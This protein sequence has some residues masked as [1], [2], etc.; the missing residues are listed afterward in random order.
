MGPLE[1]AQLLTDE[2]SAKILLATFKN[3]QSAMDLSH[4][5]GIPLAACYRR[6]SQLEDFG[7]IECVER[8]LTD[9]GKRINLYESRLKHAYVFFENGKLRTRF[10]ISGGI[11]KEIGGDWTTDSIRVDDPAS[12]AMATYHEDFS[13]WV[14][15][16]IQESDREFLSKEPNQTKEGMQ[17][18][19]EELDIVEETLR[20]LEHVASVSKKAVRDLREIAAR[21]PRTNRS[22]EEAPEGL[23]R[24]P[25]IP[26]EVAAK[27]GKHSKH[28]ERG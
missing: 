5:Y 12:S 20:I 25:G 23:E 2:Y 24:V 22:L 4:K 11:T 13:P 1:A 3:R 28:G 6:L 8:T 15:E 16:S 26:K 7:L 21:A 19:I 10:T 9:K 14:D 18:D 27:T 17:E